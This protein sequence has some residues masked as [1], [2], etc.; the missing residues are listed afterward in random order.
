MADSYIQLNVTVSYTQSIVWRSAVSISPLPLLCQ[1]HL[2]ARLYMHAY[3]RLCLCE[4]VR[5]SVN[6][7]FTA[8]SSER[9]EVFWWNWS[10]ITLSRSLGQR[11][12]PASVVKSTTPEP[13]MRVNWN[14]H[15]YFL[16]SGHELVRFKGQG[17][18]YVS[19]R[20]V[21]FVSRCFSFF[22]GMSVLTLALCARLSWLLVSF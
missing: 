8:I 7:F 1:R 19:W 9:V 15:R 5:E 10:L 13:M 22:S 4:S 3:V 21:F 6:P 11:S 16:Q 2:A 18:I 12:R 14:L 20:K 17:H